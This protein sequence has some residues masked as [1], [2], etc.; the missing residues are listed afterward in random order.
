MKEIE[1]GIELQYKIFDKIYIEICAKYSCFYS[2]RGIP[3]GSCEL[4]PKGFKHF[5][6]WIH[7]C[8]FWSILVGLQ[9]SRIVKI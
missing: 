7:L 8:S 3:K 5:C 6:L 2:T 9:C 4:K 1:K